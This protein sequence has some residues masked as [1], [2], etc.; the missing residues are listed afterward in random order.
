MPP[1]QESATVPAAANPTDATAVPPPQIAATAAATTP[2]STTPVAETP[3]ITLSAIT[4]TITSKSARLQGKD[5]SNPHI[6]SW[7]DREGG[8]VWT[9]TISQA[10][11]YSVTI[12][13]ACNRSGAGGMAKVSAGPAAISETVVDTGSWDTFAPH[14]LRQPLEITQA[15]EVTITLEAEV[16][17]SAAFM[18]FSS[19]VLAPFAENP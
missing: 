14:T 1:T 10:G 7:N 16:K 17:K 12:T 11:R 5:S 9:T 2:E 6:G 13:Y 15:G 8:L 18:K 4:A 3:A 19:L